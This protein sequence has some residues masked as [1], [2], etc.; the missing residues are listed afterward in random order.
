VIRTKKLLLIAKSFYE[1]FVEN[2]VTLWRMRHE[3]NRRTFM[4]GSA[5]VMGAALL[6][7]ETFAAS[8]DAPPRRRRQA[9]R[10]GSLLNCI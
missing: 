1:T 2:R 4:A 8:I 5:S 7:A 3:L 9:M 6:P 10:W